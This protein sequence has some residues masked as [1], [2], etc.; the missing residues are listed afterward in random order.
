MGVCIAMSTVSNHR[1]GSKSTEKSK[2]KRVNQQSIVYWIW[3]MHAV[4]TMEEEVKRTREI[5]VFF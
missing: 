1:S 2:V 5:R 4:S 3:M